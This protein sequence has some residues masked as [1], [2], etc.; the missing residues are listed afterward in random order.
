MKSLL[1][2]GERA[3]V[4]ISKLQDYCLNMQHLR[5]RHKARVFVSVLG[6]RYEDAEMLRQALLDAARSEHATPGSEDQ[7]G[8]RYMIDFE[9]SGPSGKAFVRSIWIVL[10][11][12]DFP[13]LTSC[14]VL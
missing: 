11:K 1:P 13:R 9:M 6:L 12:E 14:Y 2:N 8:A 5:G 4:E 3:V 10:K 7:Y